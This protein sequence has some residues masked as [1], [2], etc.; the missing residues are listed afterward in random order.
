MLVTED[1]PMIRKALSLALAAALLALP[2][3]PAAAASLDR[4]GGNLSQT[5]MGNDCCY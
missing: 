2:V 4:D 3:A 5:R 1:F